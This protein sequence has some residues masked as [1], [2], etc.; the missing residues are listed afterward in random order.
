MLRDQITSWQRK[1]KY[2]VQEVVVVFLI[3]EMYMTKHRVVVY[4][5][6]ALR[7]SWM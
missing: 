1:D 7:H 3:L 5:S 6:A 4:G 2:F